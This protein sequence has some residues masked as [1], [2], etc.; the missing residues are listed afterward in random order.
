MPTVVV[1]VDALPLTANGKIDRAALT[2][3]DLP[4]DVPANSACGHRTAPRTPTERRIAEIWRTLLES[5]D[6]GA[7]DDFFV[8]GGHSL[9]A[10]RLAMLIG[11]RTG[12]EV[13]L[14]EVFAHSTVAAQAALVDRRPSGERSSGIPR[15]DGDG[16]LPAS[17]AQ[18]RQWFL[19]Q[20]APHDTTY[21]V[22]WVDK[23]EAAGINLPPSI[24]GIG[25]RR[26]Y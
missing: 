26:R 13:S 17:H 23:L 7:H 19:W 24:F 11:E 3:P 18:E 15:V 10:V 25:E 22:P 2:L 8:L 21:T 6:V 14:R 4:D 20:L 16:D 9:L 5:D 12:A 1:A